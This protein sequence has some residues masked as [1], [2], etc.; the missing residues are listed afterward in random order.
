MQ[1]STLKAKYVL[2]ERV[3]WF[4]HN[5]YVMG[6]TGHGHRT[7]FT[8]WTHIHFDPLILHAHPPLQSGLTAVK[9][10]QSESHQDVCDILLQYSQQSTKVTPPQQE[11]SESTQE[12]ETKAE[13]A[14]EVYG[15]NWRYKG[16]EC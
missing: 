3:T 11:V 2:F 15:G 4:C 5:V 8:A 10:A 6:G 1:L 9:V 12:E 7:I 16:I 13:L 14:A